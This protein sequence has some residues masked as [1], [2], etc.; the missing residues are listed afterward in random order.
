MWP[1][2]GYNQRRH[3]Q[4]ERLA[5]MDRSIF[6]ATEYSPPVIKEGRA[7]STEEM[8]DQ[9]GA[10]DDVIRGDD[11]FRALRAE[12]LQS[13]KE[14][15]VWNKV[16]RVYENGETI[17]GKIIS[18]VKGGLCVDIGVKAFLPGSQIDLRPVKDLEALIGT[19]HHFKILRYDERQE[20]IVLSRRAILEAERIAQRERL[21][22]QLRAGAVLKG[23]VKN[24]AA[25]G[26]FVD[27]GGIDG[28]AHISDLSWGRIG[29]PSEA[30]QIGD[31]INVKV[32]HF[33]KEKERVSLGI[34]QLM[35]DPW[36]GVEANYPPGTKINGRV[37]SLTD[38]GAFVQIE[39]GVEGLLHV[40]EISRKQKI[41]HPSQI[42]EVGDMVT[43]VI[44]DLDVA[45]RRMALSMKPFESNPWSIIEKKYPVGTTIKGRIKSMTNFGMFLG[46]EAGLDGLVHI[47]DIS[48]SRGIRHPSERYREGQEVKA[49]VLNIDKRKERLSLGMKQLKPD[50]WGMVDQKLKPGDRVT[51]VV[52]HIAPFGVFVEI[53]EGIEGLIHV[54]E[55]A[56]NGTSNALSRFQ[57]SDVIQ[58]AVIRISQ[59][60]KKIG[61]S[62]RALE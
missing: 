10:P 15:E 20:N 43:A 3:Q 28:L 13:V 39:N 44:L 6:F 1:K 35:P 58:V 36:H 2:N 46:V 33:D 49:V 7:D 19:E 21:L 29:H 61:L 4:A 34:K 60:E 42:L 59:E 50:P 30:Y 23:T 27:L 52:S 16:K 22:G 48:W 47:S 12:S 45:R 5:K 37:L 26:V 24:I 14:K 8:A 11:R 31:E 32:L 41:T 9:S 25:Y 55:L 40:S 18:L 51:G 38:Y 57:V 62:I 17:H 56:G 54:S 53:E